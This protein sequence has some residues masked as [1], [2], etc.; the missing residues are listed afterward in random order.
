MYVGK[1]EKHMEGYC[2]IGKISDIDIENNIDYIVEVV[3]SKL[4]DLT[5][6]RQLS[7]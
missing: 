1:F 7:C 2:D 5:S 3:T 6:E 4:F